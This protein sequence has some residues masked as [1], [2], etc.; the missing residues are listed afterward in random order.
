[1]SPNTVATTNTLQS[2]N[3]TTPLLSQGHVE[4]TSQ[5]RLSRLFCKITKK[6]DDITVARELAEWSRHGTSYLEA[7][8]VRVFA[9]PT[10]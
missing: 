6:P 5:S 1:M 2:N 3:D 9:T 7:T 8:I 10:R 4:G